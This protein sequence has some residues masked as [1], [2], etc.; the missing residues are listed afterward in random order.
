MKHN[1][2]ERECVCV[3]VCVREKVIYTKK[4]IELQHR[5]KAA[6]QRRDY[7]EGGLGGGT[8]WTRLLEY[9]YNM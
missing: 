5:E 4:I 1:K 9:E 8:G 3:Y 2:R 7:Y 6:L